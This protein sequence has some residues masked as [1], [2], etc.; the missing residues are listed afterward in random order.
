MRDVLEGLMEVA[1]ETAYSL[2]HESFRLTI[3]S[4]E[5]PHTRTPMSRATVL[6]IRAQRSSDVLTYLLRREQHRISAE[7]RSI[8]TP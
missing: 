4:I 5:S 3:L 7:T 2:N 1:C 8:H 6:P